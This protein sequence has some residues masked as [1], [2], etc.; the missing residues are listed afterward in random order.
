GCA[1]RRCGAVAGASRVATRRHGVRAHALELGS[2]LVECAGPGHLVSRVARGS[3]TVATGSAQLVPMMV[4]S[5]VAVVVT[6]AGLLA[7]DWR[8]GLVG[9]VAIPMYG[10]SLRWYLPR[11][12]PV[13]ASERAAFA[14]RAGHLRGGITG[15]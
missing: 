10:W 13:Y 11:S 5:L 12:G 14:D 7:S 8:L 15:V 6:A 1:G 2:A 9:M 4:S 3:R